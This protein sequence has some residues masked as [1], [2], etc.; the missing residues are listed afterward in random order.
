MA[1]QKVKLTKVTTHTAIVD[2]ELDG[3]SNEALDEALADYMSKDLEEKF[4]SDLNIEWELDD[5]EI[6][7]FEI[8]EYHF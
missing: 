3:D 1:T 4:L 7:E 6:A 8:D 5:E 2:I